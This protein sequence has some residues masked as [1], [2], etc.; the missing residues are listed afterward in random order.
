MSLCSKAIQEF[1]KC[2]N[3]YKNDLVPEIR[4]VLNLQVCAIS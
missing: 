3:A 2:N 1:K 4:K